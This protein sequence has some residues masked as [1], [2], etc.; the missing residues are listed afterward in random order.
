MGIVIASFFQMGLPIITHGPTHNTVGFPLLHMVS[1]QSRKRQSYQF[2]MAYFHLLLLTT[3]AKRRIRVNLI[4]W[5]FLA[6]A[7]LPL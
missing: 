5:R 6:H 4:C 7:P 3:G 2:L 1:L